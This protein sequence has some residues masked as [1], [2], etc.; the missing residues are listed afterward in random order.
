[1]SA[2][3]VRR[4]DPTTIAMIVGAIAVWALL[5]FLLAQQ[6]AEH[7]A[8]AR[9]WQAEKAAVVAEAHALVLVRLKDPASAQ[10]G[11]DRIL[12]SGPDRRVCGTVNARNTY[13]GYSGADRYVVMGGYAFFGSDRPP[14]A[15]WSRPEHPCD[16]F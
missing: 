7:E 11:E 8:P 13:G 10:F 5:A 3:S 16:V 12:G 6:R 2:M 14:E 9:E 15:V 1:M 4:P